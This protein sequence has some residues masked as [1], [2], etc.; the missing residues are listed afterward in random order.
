MKKL[1]AVIGAPGT[2]K[3]TAMKEYMDLW[4]W[5]YHRTGLVDHYVSGDI[6]VLGRYDE[7]E[8]FGGTDR[9]SMSVMPE[10]IEFLNQNEDKVIVFEGDR[11]TSKKFFDTAIESG[12]DLSIIA[13]EVGETERKRR[14]EERGSDQNETWLAGRI[15]KVNN[16][17]EEFGPQQ[18]L[19]GEEE[20]Y[21]KKFFHQTPEDTQRIV[22]HI[23]EIINDSILDEVIADL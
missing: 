9:L 22:D 3:T 20:G 18:T 5:E 4:E 7:G 14:Y 19:F 21:V 11:L 1:I 15:S 2:G 12:W 16:I 23:Q 8:T 6:I 17:I 10:V 13:L